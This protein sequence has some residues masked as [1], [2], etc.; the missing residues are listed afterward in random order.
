MGA[1][2]SGSS[3]RP[4]HRTS[5]NAIESKSF[6]YGRQMC[7]AGRP[8]AEPSRADP[9]GRSSMRTYADLHRSCMPF[10]LRDGSGQAISLWSR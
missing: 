4:A 8:V 10:V 5:D 7:S 3:S 9:T 2:N 6:V 1:K